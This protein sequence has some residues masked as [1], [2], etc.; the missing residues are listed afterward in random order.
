MDPAGRDDGAD[1]D[2][3]RHPPGVVGAGPQRLRHHRH[4]AG[5]GLGDRYQDQHPGGG[6]NRGRQLPGRNRDHPR[7]QPRLRREQR[8]GQGLGDRHRHRQSVVGAIPVGDRGAPRSRSPPT[9]PGPT[10][11][12]S[13][14]RR[15]LGDRYPA[16]TPCWGHRSRSAP[17]LPG[18]RSPPTAAAPTSPTPTSERRGDRHRGRRRVGAPIPVGSSPIGLAITPDGEP[19]LRRQLGLQ[20]RLGDRH[21]DQHGGGGTDRRRLR[22]E[23]RS[24]SL[25]DGSRAYV[26]NVG[27][28]NVSVIDTADQHSGR[29]T[30]RSR[31]QPGRDRDHPRRQP[32]L[33][34]QQRLGGTVTV[35]DTAD[36]HR[37]TGAT[38]GRRL[39]RVR[40]S[41]SPQ[42]SLRGQGSVPRPGS[43]RRP[44]RAPDQATP[45]A[46]SPPTRWF[47]GD[48]S[49]A[50]DGRPDRE[51]PLPQGGS[52]QGQAH[53]LRRRGL[54]DRVGVHRPDRLLQWLLARLGDPPRGHLQ[55]CKAAGEQGEGH[56]EADRQGARPRGT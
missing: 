55:A 30:D 12:T 23:Q 26:I 20:Q 48:G 19:R 16:A 36:Q 18:S 41:R 37:A 4:R 2:C 1:S 9:A 17:T 47:F 11:P 28:D 52:V 24:R 54:L 44:S 8:L 53:G 15:R 13:E 51:A 7:R 34:R 46:G 43:S 49:S 21:H 33:R 25:P 22:P 6:A 29:G 35:I 31:S 10:S 45:T 38:D 5:H 14:L 56:R 32:G 42:T 50:N 3:L 39:Q 40:R 27:P